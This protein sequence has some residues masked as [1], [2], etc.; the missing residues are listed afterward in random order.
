MLDI[1]GWFCGILAMAGSLVVT[2]AHARRRRVAF[3][4][5]IIAN[6]GFLALTV[7]TGQWYFVAQYLFFLTTASLGF[8]NNRQPRPPSPPSAPPR[9]CGKSTTPSVPRCLRG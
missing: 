6:A 4:M 7:T 9:L 1:L 8:M 3:G 2:S 5:W